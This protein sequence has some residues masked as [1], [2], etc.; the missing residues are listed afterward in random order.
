MDAQLTIKGLLIFSHTLV[1]TLWKTHVEKQVKP[2]VE[3][4]YV[5]MYMH[6]IPGHS[7]DKN[8]N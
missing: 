7:G 6:R 5:G 4:M 1:V 3:Y 2:R 8:N